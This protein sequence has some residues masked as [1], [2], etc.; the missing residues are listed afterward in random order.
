MKKI[1]LFVAFA[2]V[3]ITA[4]T[5]STSGGD[6]PHLQSTAVARDAKFATTYYP[7]KWRGVAI[8]P[9]DE[10]FMYAYTYLINYASGT[11]TLMSGPTYAMFALTSSCRSE[12]LNSNID[13]SC[14]SGCRTW[15]YYYTPAPAFTS[16]INY[17]AVGCP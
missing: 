15:S 13:P 1:L 2:V 9:A 3:G 5:R 14:T 12:W 10:E 8:D 7:S 11:A 6:K 4:T 17:L 16:N